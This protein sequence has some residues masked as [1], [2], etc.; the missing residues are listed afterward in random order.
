MHAFF[1]AGTDGMPCDLISI[2]GHNPQTGVQVRSAQLAQPDFIAFEAVVVLR[3]RFFVSV[4]TF[5][6]N[7]L[8][9]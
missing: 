6:E 8:E 1:I 4:L 3:E 7:L 2:P 9:H 5:S